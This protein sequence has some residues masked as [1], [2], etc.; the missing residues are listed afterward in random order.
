M[1]HYSGKNNL[2]CINK[3]IN[4]ETNN[5]PILL[6]NQEKIFVQNISVIFVTSY[7]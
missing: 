7:E 1:L 2:K 5:K 6:T 3:Y 4:K